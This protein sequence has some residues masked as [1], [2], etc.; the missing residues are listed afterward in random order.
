MLALA[1]F[2]LEA[3]P[4]MG[5]ARELP[6]ARPYISIPVPSSP[7][8]HAMQ[9]RGRPRIP[10]KTPSGPSLCHSHLLP[11]PA[12]PPRCCISCHHGTSRRR[13]RKPPSPPAPCAPHLSPPKRRRHAAPPV[14]HPKNFWDLGAM[15]R[16]W[17][18]Q[19]AAGRE[20]WALHAPLSFVVL[21]EVFPLLGLL[22]GRYMRAFRSRGWGEVRGGEGRGRGLGGGHAWNR[23]GWELVWHGD[24]GGVEGARGSG[25]REGLVGDWR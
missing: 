15:R 18:G 4:T 8:G 12:R 17:V 13:P 16:L 1:V 24:A 2:E 9:V 22:G 20:G 7:I 19:S 21:R 6:K 3:Y 25:I 5:P 11:P 23:A 10:A 14:G